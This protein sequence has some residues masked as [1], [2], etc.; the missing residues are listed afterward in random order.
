MARLIRSSRTP[1]VPDL[2]AVSLLATDTQYDDIFITVCDSEQKDDLANV[3][4][5]VNRRQFGQIRS[6]YCMAA[7][8]R[9]VARRR[10]STIGVIAVTDS[11]ALGARA[12]RID[13]SGRRMELRRQNRQSP[14]GTLL[15]KT[16]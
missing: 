12:K 14:I 2:Q 13:N 8:I 3:I 11:K 5:D 10:K 15:H 4:S 6:N 16:R 7:V 1:E 9:P